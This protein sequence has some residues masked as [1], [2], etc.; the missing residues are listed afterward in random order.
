MIHAFW[1]LQ[2]RNTKNK[3]LLKGTWMF[4][5]EQTT[6][7]V[8]RQ[9]ALCCK[10]TGAAIELNDVYVWEWN[11]WSLFKANHL[12][13]IR[14]IPFFWKLKMKNETACSFFTFWGKIRLNLI[15]NVLKNWKSEKWI[16]KIQ[17]S[18]YRKL[19]NDKLKFIFNFH[20]FWWKQTWKRYFA[21]RVPLWWPEPIYLRVGY[22]F[23]SGFSAGMI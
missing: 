20:F 8:W 14:F 5:S 22:V 13:C 3:P 2:V 18:F 1:N 11:K 16:M 10:V 21:P 4:P 23:E 9:W 12:T 19:T 17:L 6:S 7:S 15:F